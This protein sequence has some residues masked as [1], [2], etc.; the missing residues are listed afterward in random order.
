MNFRLSDHLAQLA[1]TTLRIERALSSAFVYVLLAFGLVLSGCQ[2]LPSQPAKASANQTEVPSQEPQQPPQV[3]PETRLIRYMDGLLQRTPQ[4]LHT[5]EQQL[6]QMDQ[7]AYNTRLSRALLYTSPNFPDTTRL[8]AGVNQLQ[9]IINGYQLGD[10]G[11]LSVLRLRHAE[12]SARQT[13]LQQQQQLQKSNQSLNSQLN[14][15]RDKLKAL[16]SIEQSIEQASP[17]PADTTP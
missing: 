12:A 8:T 9:Q 5:V 2:T 1:T 15:I 3:S 6:D 13:A 17:P 10:P 4:Q 16:T 14:S 11:A 7:N